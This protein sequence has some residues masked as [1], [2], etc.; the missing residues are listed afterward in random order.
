S[1]VQLQRIRRAGVQR[2]RG[3]S[4]V[5]VRGLVH[6]GRRIERER[7]GREN[8]IRAGQRHA[9]DG[10]VPAIEDRGAGDVDQ[11]AGRAQIEAQLAVIDG[12]AAER[13]RADDAVVCTC[14]RM[15]AAAV[16]ARRADTAG[17]AERGAGDVDRATWI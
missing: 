10:N 9:C 6:T 5:R 2:I 8:G 13:G 16:H 4:Q 12:Q 1:D 17:A 3:G 11:V 7:A 15:D 14:A